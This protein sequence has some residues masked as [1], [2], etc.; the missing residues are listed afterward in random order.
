MI[1]T[2]DFLKQERKESLASLLHSN[3]DSYESL[4]FTPVEQS[5]RVSNAK[6]G[7]L[8]FIKVVLQALREIFLSH[9]IYAQV[10]FDNN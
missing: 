1:G 8:L 9:D 5:T 10:P 4:S 6:I 7:Q 2:S 3:Q